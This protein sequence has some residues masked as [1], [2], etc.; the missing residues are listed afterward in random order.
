M[1]LIYT[2]R[3]ASIDGENARIERDNLRKL[4]SSSVK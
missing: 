2:L 3:D 4:N 1:K